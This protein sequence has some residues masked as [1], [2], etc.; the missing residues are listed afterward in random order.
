MID[1]LEYKE[2]RGGKM[3]DLLVVKSKIKDYVKNMNVAGDFAKELDKQVKELIKDAQQRAK[4][5][6]RRTVMAKDL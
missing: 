1:N 2:L 6:N 5:N 4:A 3:A